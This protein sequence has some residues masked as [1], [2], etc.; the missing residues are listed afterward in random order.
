M[1]LTKK[2]RATLVEAIGRLQSESDALSIL[3]EG[4]PIV[5]MG[6]ATEID[7]PDQETGKIMIPDMNQEPVELDEETGKSVMLTD[8]INGLR[9]VTIS[10][11]SLRKDRPPEPAGTLYKLIVRHSMAG[12]LQGLADIAQSTSKGLS[13]EDIKRTAHPSVESARKE[14][15]RLSV[16]L[17]QLAERCARFMGGN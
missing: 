3:L 1:K 7:S 5:N 11:D 4:L 14:T 10:L 9:A 13:A 16:E 6:T 2:E 8:A 12:V 15:A 17:T